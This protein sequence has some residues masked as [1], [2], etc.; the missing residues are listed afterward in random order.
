MESNE[1][2]GNCFMGSSA[3]CAG[4]DNIGMDLTPV[5]VLEAKGTC[6]RCEVVIGTALCIL[7]SVESDLG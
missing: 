2:S 6:T 1:G 5:G 3:H 4:S 7:E